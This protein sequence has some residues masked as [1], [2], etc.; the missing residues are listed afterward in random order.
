MNANRRNIKMTPI[1]TLLDIEEISE[2]GARSRHLG[3]I[4]KH[5]VNPYQRIYDVLDDIG[6]C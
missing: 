1:K 2:I 6:G 3:R 4:S 5:A